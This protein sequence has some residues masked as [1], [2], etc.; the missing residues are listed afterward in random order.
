M[1]NLVETNFISESRTD[2]HNQ[3]CALTF[4]RNNGFARIGIGGPINRVLRGHLSL[5]ER[6]I[7]A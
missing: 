7:H 1:L 5:I 4:Y 3:T 6:S 2:L